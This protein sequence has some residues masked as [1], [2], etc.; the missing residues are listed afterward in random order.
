MTFNVPPL[1]FFFNAT[2]PNLTSFINAVAPYLRAGDYVQVHQ[3]TSQL[4]AILAAKTQMQAVNSLCTVQATVQYVQDCVGTTLA[5]SVGAGL[6]VF[7]FDYECGF[8]TPIFTVD[9]ASSYARF[10]TQN[11]DVAAYNTRTGS[12]CK[13]QPD[14]S[15]K[16]VTVASRGTQGFCGSFNKCGSAQKPGTGTCEPNGWDWALLGSKCQIC[17]I[18][19][20]GYTASD[21]ATFT[22]VLQD[23]AAPM[24]AANPS[25]LV[26]VQISLLKYTPTIVQ[27]AIGFIKNSGVAVDGIFIYHNMTV[28]GPRNSLTKVRQLLTNLFG[29]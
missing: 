26:F 15:Y 23:C 10:N 13:F 18:Q 22:A 16:Q 1:M 20:G 9:Q 5:N 21:Q 3:G 24:K 2:D 6:D 28:T 14:P 11:A 17:N 27:N 19:M 7:A 29:F 25:T 4:A 12:T 8:N